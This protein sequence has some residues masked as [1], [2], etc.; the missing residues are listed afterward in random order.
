MASEITAELALEIKEFLN[1]IKKSQNAATNFS[2]KG[3][4]GTSGWSQGL[5]KLA[6]GI[7]KVAKA[8]AIAGAA[9]A[10]VG[11]AAA[12]G[13]AK[14]IKG[15]LDMGGKFSDLAAQ[16]GTT[17]GKARVLAAAFENNGMSADQVAVTVNKMSKAFN[18]ANNG[19]A[20][21]QRAFDELGLDPKQLIKSDPVAAF[22]SVMGALSGVENESK[23]VALSM[24]VFGRAGGKLGVLLKDKKAMENAE[25]LIGGQAALLDK[26]A[27]KF[28]RAS[29][30]L[31]QMGTKVQGFF[32]GVGAKIID[33]I[34]PAIEYINALDLTGI[35]E[36]FGA[37]LANALDVVIAIVRVFRSMSLGEVA[38]LFGVLFRLGIAKAINFLFK[39]GNA[40]FSALIALFI[41]GIKNSVAFLSIL[42]TKGFWS[43]MLNVLLGIAQA[44]AGFILK[45]LSQTITAIKEALPRIGKRVFGDSDEKLADMGRDLGADSKESFSKAGTDLAP[46][47]EKISERMRETGKAVGGAFARTFDKTTDIIDTSG[48]EGVVDGFVQSVKDVAQE[49]KKERKDK[50]KVEDGAAGDA[51]SEGGGGL[52]ALNS[53]L[54]GAINT[55]AGRSA[56]AVIAAESAKTSANTERTA[57]AAETI[58]ENTRPQNT[59]PTPKPKAG[60]GKFA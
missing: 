52:P 1:G 46:A 22:Q 3:K 60:S 26:N 17:A 15:A 28:D 29:D 14:G 48:D 2:K 43:G 21:S 30:V 25:A 47:F 41:E 7:A 59:R 40:V 49:I 50:K 45:R 27:E 34:L 9:I 4:D 6:G 53:R 39:T 20:T 58:A 42:G 23:R 31:N 56:N 8:A 11:T 57:K 32:V 19:L 10:A 54:A 16:M 37:A 51:Q 35:G 38:E 12:V 24:D 36:R 13:L 33:Q 55:I 5:G 44:F 18:D